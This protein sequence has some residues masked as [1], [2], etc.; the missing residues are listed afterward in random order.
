MEHLKQ[1]AGAAVQAAALAAVGPARLSTYLTR[2][3]GDPSQALSYY[4][5]NLLLSGAAYETTALV[6]VAIRNA[7]DR[8]LRAWNASQL[9]PASSRRHRAEWLLDPAPLLKRLLKGDIT[10]AQRRFAQSRKG[11]SGHTHDDL[12]A[13]VDFSTWRY[14]LPD[15]DPG[16]QYLWSGALNFAFPALTGSVVRLVRSVD[17]I[18]RH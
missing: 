16:K 9:D 10:K 13:Q 12:I 6:E 8:E 18:Y 17:G 1:G 15:G 7:M 4:H 3:N 5:F 14:L 11:T 2:A